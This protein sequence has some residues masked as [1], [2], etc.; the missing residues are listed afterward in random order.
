[1]NTSAIA[2]VCLL[3]EGTYPYVLG[4]VSAWVDQI[5]RGLPDVSF[6][7]FFIGSTKEAASKQVYQLPPNVIGLSETFVH[8]RLP[9]EELVAAPTPHLLRQRIYAEL[10]KFYLAEDVHDQAAGIWPLTQVLEE[11]EGKFTYGNLCQDREAWEILQEVYTRNA[12]GTSFIDC[13]WTARFLHLPIWTLWRA[14]GSLPRARVYHSISAGYAG[15]MAALAAR[16]YQAPLKPSITPLPAPPS[17]LS[18]PPPV[19]AP[20]KV[21]PAAATSTSF[22]A[23]LTATPEYPSIT[24]KF[25]TVPAAAPL[26]ETPTPPTISAP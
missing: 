22:D 3:L 7:L 15:L 9:P 1:M 5:I 21:E 18:V 14:R 4:G 23:R 10:R 25:R 24:P 19:T 13:F 11:A 8:S 6:H 26:I 2:D 20:M 16:R 17:R 12:P